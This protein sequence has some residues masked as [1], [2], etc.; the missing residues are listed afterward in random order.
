MTSGK[1]LP[2][3][4]SEQAGGRQGQSLTKEGHFP[5]AEGMGQT[6]GFRVRL[7]CIQEPGAKGEVDGETLWE[8]RG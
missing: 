1:K 6:G 2:S 4:W 3:P 7:G 5:G 8:A